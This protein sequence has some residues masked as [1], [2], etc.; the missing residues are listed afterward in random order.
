[1]RYAVTTPVP[2]AELPYGA[3]QEENP[4]SIVMMN[5]IALVAPRVNKIDLP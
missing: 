4:I 2:L 1:M 3:A 5:A